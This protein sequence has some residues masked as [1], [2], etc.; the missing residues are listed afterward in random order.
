MQ[1]IT[2][3]KNSQPFPNRYRTQKHGEKV[4]M[5]SPKPDRAARVVAKPSIPGMFRIEFGCIERG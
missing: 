5:F 2:R 1:E 3:Q 4:Y